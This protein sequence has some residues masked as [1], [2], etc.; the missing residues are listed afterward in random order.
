MG[1]DM[2]KDLPVPQGVSVIEVEIYPQSSLGRQ[3]RAPDLTLGY[4]PNERAALAR[5]AASCGAP[6]ARFVAELLEQVIEEG[7]AQRCG[8]I[9]RRPGCSVGPERPEWLIRSGDAA[10]YVPQCGTVTSDLISTP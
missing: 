9:V 1:V 5:S 6:G 8:L 4:C 3:E 10:Q 2:V 7:L